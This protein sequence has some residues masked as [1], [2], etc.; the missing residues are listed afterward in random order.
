MYEYIFAG[1]FCS[2]Y[3]FFCCVFGY[4]LL[5]ERCTNNQ[6]QNINNIE[7]G[8]NFNDEYV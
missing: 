1:L 3:A 8:N 5:K 6:Y 4:S 2:Y 7:L